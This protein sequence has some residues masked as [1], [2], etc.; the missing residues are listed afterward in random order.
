VRGLREQTQRKAVFLFCKTFKADFYFL[1]ET[2]ALS[3]DVNFWRNQ[4]GNNI[5]MSSGNSKSAGVAVLKAPF[6]ETLHDSG[7]WVILVIEFMENYFILGY[8]VIII[9]TIYNTHLFA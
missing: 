3:S 8:M 9:V 4:C 5:W 6:R 2:H 7:R 1:Q